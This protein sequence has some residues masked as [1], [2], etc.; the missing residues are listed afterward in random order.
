MKKW[1]KHLAPKQR[2]LPVFLI[3]I[4]A[5][6]RFLE[7]IG[8]KEDPF[9]NKVRNFGLFAAKDTNKALEWEIVNPKSELA[10]SLLTLVVTCLQDISG[11]DYKLAKYKEVEDP[12]ASLLKNIGKPAL[13]THY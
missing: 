5:V 12:L 2:I 7:V 4:Q 1:A 13:F 6:E 9:E 8:I 10:C 3:V 11:I